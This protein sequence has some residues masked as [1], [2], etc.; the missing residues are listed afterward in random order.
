[1][2]SL[3]NL[4]GIMYVIN[5]A[6]CSMIISPE[7]FL[8]QTGCQASLLGYLIGKIWVRAQESVF[9][10]TTPGNACMQ[11]GFRSADLFPSVLICLLCWHCEVCVSFHA[12]G[13]SPE[14]SLSLAL[15][16]KYLS[17]I[18]FIWLY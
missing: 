17:I 12:Y 4:L 16:Y 2:H 9:L 13:Y 7:A 1:M 14:L 3:I 18:Y 15:F 11:P 6:V 10:T 8:P 5:I